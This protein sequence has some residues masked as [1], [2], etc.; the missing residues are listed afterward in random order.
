MIFMGNATYRP[1][2]SWILF[3]GHISVASEDICIK[4]GR[5]IDIGHVGVTMAQIPTVVKFKMAAAAILKIHK[6]VYIGPLLTDL[7]QI[8]ST[9]L[10]WPYASY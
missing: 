6:Q 1:P 5:S 4:F 9:A 2:P 10:Y 7:H 8:W 3:F